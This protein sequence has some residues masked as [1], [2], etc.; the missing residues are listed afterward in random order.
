[1]TGF[2]DQ[3][4]LVTGGSSGIGFALAEALCKQGA[5]VAITGTHAGK[6][7][8]AVAAIEAQGGVITSAC[9]DVSNA[10]AWANAV[11]EIEATLGPIDSLFLNA[12]V[13][14]DSMPIEDVPQSV[15]RWIWDVNMMGTV[16]GLLACLPGMKQR[17]RA[18]HVLITSSIGAFVPK[19]GMA[20]YAVTKAG[21]V[22]LAENLANELE[23]TSIGVSVLMPAAVRTDFNN[24]SARLAPSDFQDEQAAKTFR[25]I[26]AVLQGGID[27]RGVADF[28][29][30]RIAEGAFY[31]FSHP[32]FRALIA[33]K[34]ERLL[35]AI[36][37]NE[38][39]RL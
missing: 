5:R 38:P 35:A 17:G 10:D 37:P 29:L 23:G 9:F 7:D 8:A 1:M 33:A 4:V 34:N 20:P 15:W 11:A 22:A 18:G 30:Q 13:G 27:P 25:D 36:P 32:D 21:L 28:V 19:L 39:C 6:L 2:K 31:I 24:T 3:T 16:N 26:G 12:G 14:T